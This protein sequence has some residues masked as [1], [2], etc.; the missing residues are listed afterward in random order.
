[1]EKKRLIAVVLVMFM[2]FS[3]ASIGTS[4]TNEGEVLFRMSPGFG[5]NVD[6]HTHD[7]HA[8]EGDGEFQAAW[9]WVEVIGDDAGGTMAA[10]VQAKATLGD[11]SWTAIVQPSSATD[12]PGQINEFEL[13]LQLYKDGAPP[14][15][16]FWETFSWST[17]GDYLTGT[18]QTIWEEMHFYYPHWLYVKGWTST[19][20]PSWDETADEHVEGNVIFTFTATEKAATTFG[21]NFE[22]L[23]S[24]NQAVEG[25][26]VT[27]DEGG[28][29]AK[30]WQTNE[31]GHARFAYL[32]DNTYPWK[33]EK[34]GYV[35]QSGSVIIDG[36][37]N[38]V[39]IK[40]MQ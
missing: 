16:D 39:D 30:S 26:T 21:V 40:L 14:D 7:V 8:T 24:E 15:S 4:A 36:G 2:M 27:V 23:D 31:W 34:D 32:P 25:A 20:T 19:D 12:I 37:Y 38:H 5:I 1:M 3:M 11:G 29:H 17:V 28:P 22:V 6:V 18:D 10:D 35:M 33:V 9:I 13:A